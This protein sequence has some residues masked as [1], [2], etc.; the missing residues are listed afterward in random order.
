MFS[1]CLRT[2]AFSLLI[3]TTNILFSM[4]KPEKKAPTLISLM[5]ATDPSK[6]DVVLLGHKKNGY[7]TKLFTDLLESKVTENLFEDIPSAQ[8]FYKKEFKNEEGFI[9]SLMI[10]LSEEG[11]PT[12]DT[13]I[14]GFPVKFEP[15]EKLRTALEKSDLK[16][17]DKDLDDLAWVSIDELAGVRAALSLPL[18]PTAQKSSITP[19]PAIDPILQA[20]IK[21]NAVKL[22]SIA[23]MRPAMKAKEPSEITKASAKGGKGFEG[24]E[25]F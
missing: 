1:F 20:K 13:V 16:G 9:K 14:I 19:K 24:F 4:D 7:W 22:K 23:K 11:K 18:S 5:V 12:G 10:G 17:E 8:K 6:R 21:E 2:A 25:G 3:L 15:I